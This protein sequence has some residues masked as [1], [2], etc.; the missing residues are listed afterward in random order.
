MRLSLRREPISPDD[1]DLRLRT[2][3][4]RG[5]GPIGS[6]IVVTVMIC[7]LWPEDTGESG[8]DDA[9]DAVIG[10]QRAF[11]GDDTLASIL[12]RLEAHVATQ[13]PTNGGLTQL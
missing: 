4:S 9:I 8:K 1:P 2:T 6:G 11:L 10:I 13:D 5:F 3:V 12:E 7:A